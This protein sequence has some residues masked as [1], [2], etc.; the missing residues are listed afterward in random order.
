MPEDKC[1][2]CGETGGNPSCPECCD[3]VTEDE[4]ED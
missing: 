2:E 4:G 3:L 1:P